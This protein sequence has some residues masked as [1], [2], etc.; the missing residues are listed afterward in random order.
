VSIQERDSLCS[1][2]RKLSRGQSGQR[3]ARGATAA[4]ESGG[5]TVGAE[6]ANRAVNR[7]GTEV[8]LIEH[9]SG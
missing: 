7:R 1:P 6:E 8:G 9:R 4:S 2:D 5:R 3:D